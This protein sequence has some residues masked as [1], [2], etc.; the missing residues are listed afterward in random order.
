[1]AFGLVLQPH[2]SALIKLIG[3]W[4][5]DKRALATVGGCEGLGK[6]LMEVKTVDASTV[7]R[8]GFTRCKDDPQTFILDVRSKKEFAKQ[9]VALSYNIRLTARGDTLL[10][11]LCQGLTDSI[12]M[13]MWSSAPSPPPPPHPTMYAPAHTSIRAAF[14]SLLFHSHRTT[15]RTP[16]T[17]RGLETAGALPLAL[18]A[19]IAA[20]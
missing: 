20:L 14:S 4:G 10:V 9:H 6:H 13:S 15:Q 5:L 2:S 17:R 1:M 19:Q 12:S 18:S 16:T 11:R 8:A 7:F 3:L